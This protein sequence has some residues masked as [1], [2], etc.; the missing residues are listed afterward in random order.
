MNVLII[1]PYFTGSHKAW[2]EGYKINSKLNVDILSL[3]GHYWKWRMHGGAISLANKFLIRNSIPDV[4]IASDMLDLT[5]FLALTR[6]QTAKIP[7]VLYMH[8]NQ[9]TYPWSEKDRDVKAGRNNHYGFINYSTGLAADKIWFN[10]SFHLESFI[11]ALRPFLKGFPDHNDLCNIEIIKEKSSVLPL[12]LSLNKFDE[13]EPLGNKV[14]DVPYLLWNHR[15]EYDKNPESFFNALCYLHKKGLEFKV[16]V[17]GENFAQ[18][19]EEFYKAK[20]IL[21]DKIVQFGYADDFE[22]YARL[23]WKADIIPVTSNQDFFGGSVVEAIYCNTIPLLP[24]RLAYPMHIEQKF[25]SDFLYSFQQEFID[26]LEYMVLNFR[27]LKKPNLR[28]Y[29]SKYDWDKMAPLYDAQVEELLF[30]K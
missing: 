14:N 1:E 4:I 25:H 13:F 28:S 17:L 20:K 5:I 6:V 7:I 3:S 12:G 8:E 23:L 19:P 30:P 11:T 16:I 29:V 22:T 2:A 27:K 15:W 26:K 10:S 21:G 18:S 24:D 9:L